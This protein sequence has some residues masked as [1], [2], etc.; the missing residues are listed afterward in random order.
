MLHYLRNPPK[1]PYKYISLNMK[2]NSKIRRKGG[3]ESQERLSKDTYVVF[4]LLSSV[5]FYF[6]VTV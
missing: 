2:Q 6:F 5:T 4:I 3:Q 1:I